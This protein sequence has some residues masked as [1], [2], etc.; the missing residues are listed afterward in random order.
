MK[1]WEKGYKLD[2]QVEDFTVGKDYLLDQKLVKYDCIASIAHARMLGKIGIL[3]KDEAQKL[4]KWLNKIISLDKK[5]RFKISKEQEDCHTAI[6][7]YLT[8]KLGDLGKK[9][10]T[11]RSRND[12]IIAA[13]RLP[14]M[15]LTSNSQETTT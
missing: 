4:V 11:A 6:E 8:K 14:V 9:I 1:L 10:H 7:N 15:F 13:L 12:Q 3:K 2:K 5:G